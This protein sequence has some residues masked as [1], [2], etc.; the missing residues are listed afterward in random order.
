MGTQTA[1]PNHH[2]AWEGLTITAM[3]VLAA[4]EAMIL[5]PLVRRLLF[6]CDWSNEFA[7]SNLELLPPALIGVLIA[8]AKWGRQKRAVEWG[9]V[10]IAAIA[11]VAALAVIQIDDGPTFM[12]MILCLAIT[13]LAAARYIPWAQSI[14]RANVSF[15]AFGIFGAIALNVPEGIEPEA[16]ESL[17]RSVASW[18]TLA[19]V[20]ASAALYAAA[21]LRL[22][23]GVAGYLMFSVALIVA[24]WYLILLVDWDDSYPSLV[25]VLVFAAMGLLAIAPTGYLILRNKLKRRYAQNG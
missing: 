5:V 17:I 10:L 23:A 11:P 8:Y 18:T 9:T 20:I 15:V 22:F 7:G 14:D 3:V 24:F 16:T 19:L 21:N 4:I 1:N 25:Q 12:V 13:G 6:I 2:P